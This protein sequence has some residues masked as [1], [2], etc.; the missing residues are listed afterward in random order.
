M[1]K[2]IKGKIYDTEDARL[3]AETGS[4]GVSKHEFSWGSER[5]YC[6]GDGEW[7]LYREG[8]PLAPFVT[9]KDED[10]M[11]GEAWKVLLRDE[12]MR[13]L[14]EHGCAHELRAHFGDDEKEI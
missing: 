12:A 4:V 2:I 3:V 8:G 1:K 14:R 7:F 6:T 11:S 10:E 9:D 5:L 13:W